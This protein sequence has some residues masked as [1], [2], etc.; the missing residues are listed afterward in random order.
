M[1][2]LRVCMGIGN[3]LIQPDNTHKCSMQVLIQTRHVFL[4]LQ[5]SYTYIYIILFIYLFF[6]ND[7]SLLAYEK[8]LCHAQLYLKEHIN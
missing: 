2:L 4:F 1:Y 3:Y 6:T 5:I 7:H 8:Q